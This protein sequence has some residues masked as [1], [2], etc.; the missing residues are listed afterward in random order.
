MADDARRWRVAGFE[1]QTTGVNMQR[2]PSSVPTDSEPLSPRPSVWSVFGTGWV[3]LILI[4]AIFAAV[5][6]W[7]MVS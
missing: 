6:M 2:N 1:R 5:L 7:E 4:L 3:L